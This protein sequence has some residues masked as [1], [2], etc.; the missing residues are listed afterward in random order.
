M[1]PL[2]EGLRSGNVHRQEEQIVFGERFRETHQHVAVIGPH[3]S[4]RDL[5]VSQRGGPR[6]GSLR[7]VGHQDLL[8]QVS[9]FEFTSG[10]EFK[11]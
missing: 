4:Q 1:D 3:Q 5:F 7:V 10:S 8:A 2:I 11:S 6:I 9:R